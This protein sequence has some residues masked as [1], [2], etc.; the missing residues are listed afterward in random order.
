MK[1]EV[2]MSIFCRYF[3]IWYLDRLLWKEKGHK[4]RNTVYLL[5]DTLLKLIDMLQNK[6]IIFI[7]IK[8]NFYF[9]QQNY[10]RMKPQIAC[11]FSIHWGDNFL[12]NSHN[13]AINVSE[14]IL[15][16]NRHPPSSLPPKSTSLS[17]NNE[18]DY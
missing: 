18:N 12:W 17:P 15:L 16:L 1:Y 3:W 7:E 8:Q 11:Q 10:H 5:V 4:I 2:E 6:T 9:S 13:L 14:F